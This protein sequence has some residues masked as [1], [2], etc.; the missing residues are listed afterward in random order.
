MVRV[1]PDPHKINMN[2]KLFFVF[3]LTMISAGPYIVYSNSNMDLVFSNRLLLVN[4]IQRTLG[5]MAFGAITFQIILGSNIDYFRSVV[6]DL[7]LKTHIANGL[8]SYSLVFIHPVLLIVARYFL[9]HEIDPFY[10]YTD[11]CVLCDGIYEHY[12][13][14]GRIALYLISIVVIAGLFRGYNKFMRLHWKKFH[15]L[16]YVAFYFVSIHAYSLGTDSSTKLFIYL[17]W[18]FQIVVS[19][20][21]LSKLHQLLLKLRS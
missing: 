20:I 6:K 11:L 3:W 15:L 7:A 18:F 12:I 21:V 16:N 19:Y 10:V 17:F 13:N 1:H 2:K 4:F 8:F 5:L 9:Y 14:F